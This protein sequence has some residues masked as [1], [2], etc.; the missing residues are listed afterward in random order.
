MSEDNGNKGVILIAGLIIALAII[1]SNLVNVSVMDTS[2]T[3]PVN[4]TS[5]A[6][7][8]DFYFDVASGKI[9]GHSAI[10]KFGHNPLASSGDDVWAGGGAYEF[11][12]ITAQAMEVRSTDA[13]D[14]DGGAGARTLLVYGLNE[15]WDEVSE[16]LTLNGTTPVPLQNTYLRMYRGVVLTAGATETN[17]GNIVVE[18]STGTEAINITALDGQTQQTI[19]TIPRGK[20]AYFIKGYVGLADDDKNG[21]V[22]EFQWQLRLNNGEIGAWAV[23]GEIGLNNIGSSYWQYQ[24][25]VPAGIIPEKSDIRMRVISSTTPLGVVGGYDLVLVDNE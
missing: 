5:I 4:V 8:R 17:E 14:T 7:G 15:T 3:M 6:S 25:G 12:P 10:N 23:K 9:E 11:Y 21:E 20:S 22:A 18:N 13:D 16:T 24:Y 19:F 2:Q 1:I